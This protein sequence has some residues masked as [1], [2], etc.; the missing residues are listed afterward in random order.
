MKTYWVLGAVLVTGDIAGRLDPIQ[1]E[2]TEKNKG[3]IKFLT[4]T[5]FKKI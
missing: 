3:Q 5:T 1:D 4:V 2:Y